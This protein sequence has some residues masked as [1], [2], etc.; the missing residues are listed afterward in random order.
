MVVGS[1]WCALS[2]DEGRHLWATIVVGLCA[3]STRRARPDFVGDPDLR[4][5]SRRTL[6]GRVRSVS[7]WWNLVLTV[8]RSQDWFGERLMYCPVCVLYRYFYFPQI[9]FAT[10]IA[11]TQINPSYSPGGDDV[12]SRIIMVPWGHTSLLPNSISISSAVFAG[13]TVV[14]NRQTD[15]PRYITTSVAIARI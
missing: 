14:T 8:V 2:V 15:R 10:R 9:T 1:V 13:F 6:S 7:V 11:A 5:G 12:H 3:S 4:H